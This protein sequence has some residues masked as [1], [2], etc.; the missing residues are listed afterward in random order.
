VR[1]PLAWHRRSTGTV[2]GDR[3]TTG[4][5][6]NLATVIDLHS[7]MIVGWALAGHMRSELVEDALK[8]ACGRSAVKPGL[9]FHSNRGSQCASKGFKKLLTKHEIE[10]AFNNGGH[11]PP[12]V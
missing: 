9:I 1:P 12:G 5:H 4:W 8:M 6:T 10:D 11:Q 7:R 3:T 2:P